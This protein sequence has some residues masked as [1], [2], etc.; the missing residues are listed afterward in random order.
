MT[1]QPI[2]LQPYQ[3]QMIAAIM[4]S[5]KM[6]GFVFESLRRRYRFQ[7]P[8]VI[9]FYRICLFRVCAKK[10]CHVSQRK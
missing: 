2:K 8:Q 7:N 3:E 1:K 5:S 10:L 9:A 4:S 6:K